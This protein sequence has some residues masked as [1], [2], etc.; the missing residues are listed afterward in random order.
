LVLSVYILDRQED[1]LDSRAVM[2][3]QTGVQQQAP[4]KA[5]LILFITF[6]FSS[7]GSLF[8]DL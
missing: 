1:R 5:I 8:L 4:K 3:N 6:D 2:L 7:M